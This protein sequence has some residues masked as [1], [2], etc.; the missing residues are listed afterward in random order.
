VEAS[1]R[2]E[3]LAT[4]FARNLL[5]PEGAFRE[6]IEAE[7][8]E[9]G[10]LRFAQ[11]FEVARQFDVSVEAVLW[12]FGFVFNIDPE[13]IQQYIEQLREQ[14]NFW[15][16]REHDVPPTRPLRFEALAIQ[17]LKQG[18]MSAGRFA[19]YLGVSRR[20]AMQVVEQEAQ[21]D[22]QIEVAHP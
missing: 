15:D 5:M 7:R 1:P 4:C 21:T 10:G 16:T 13:K 2:E 14:T 18:A 9:H 19:E 20:E 12:Q 8:S 22:A 3:Q 11:L 17:A 6:A